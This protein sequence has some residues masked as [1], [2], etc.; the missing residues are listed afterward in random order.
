M[1]APGRRIS[2]RNLRFDAL[3]RT[4][5]R[6][7]LAKVNR[8]NRHLSRPF[9]A[10]EVRQAVTIAALKTADKPASEVR[11]PQHYI[12]R[13]AI[14]DFI[15]VMRRQ[16][17]NAKALHVVSREARVWTTDGPGTVELDEIQARTMRQ[18][19]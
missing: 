2:K 8:F 9:P 14:N 16:K 4:H 15:S 11:Y 19:P 13:A 18:I 12:A 1:R 7:A 5:Y 6:D 3:M 10:D 17:I